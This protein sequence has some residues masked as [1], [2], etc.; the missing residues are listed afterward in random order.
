MIV[1]PATIART[2]SRIGPYFGR[3]RVD[4]TLCQAQQTA[5]AIIKRFPSQ[6]SMM[7]NSLVPKST[8]AAAPVND[9]VIPIRMTA[10]KCSFLIATAMRN[11]KTG[12][13]A[14]NSAAL[15]AFVRSSPSTKMKGYNVFPS[16][17]SHRIPRRSL[18]S[19]GSVFTAQLE[20]A[21]HRD[22]RDHEANCI[23]RNGMKITVHQLHQR[24]VE[25]P[26]HNHT[27]EQ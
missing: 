25:T 16:K 15:P 9:R 22:R 20:N 14:M 26:D 24:E 2:V 23:E 7:D 6:E 13:S 1:V 5:A 3:R 27:N 12:V 19:I 8:M 21:Q 4:S 11:A 17:P 18:R 10:L